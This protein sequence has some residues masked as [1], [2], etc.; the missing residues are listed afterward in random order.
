[1]LKLFKEHYQAIVKRGLITDRTHV[2]EFIE[3]HDEETKEMK[4]AY[5]KYS[6]TGNLDKF[7][8]EIIDTICTLTNMLLH[9]DIDVEIELKKKY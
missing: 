2:F 7:F 8:H 4:E 5:S 6:N 1:M 3:K 9:F